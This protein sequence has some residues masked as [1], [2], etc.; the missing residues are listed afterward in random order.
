MAP[1][2]VNDNQ[3]RQ[4]VLQ[5]TQGYLEKKFTKVIDNYCTNTE[6]NLK[7]LE[8]YSTGLYHMNDK[9]N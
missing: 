6:E 9:Y 1:S 5:E 4:L 8:N 3:G 2:M 7:L